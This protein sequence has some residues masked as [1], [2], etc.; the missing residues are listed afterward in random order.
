VGWF[1]LAGLALAVLVV[2]AVLFVS[3]RR[4]PRP[5]PP[6]PE[7]AA[8][9]S[10]PEGALPQPHEQ[11]AAALWR[12]AEELARSGDFLAAVRTLYLAVLSLLHRQ[13]LL[14]YEPTRTNG[15][16]VRQVRLADGAPPDLHVP[17]E[18]LTTR[19][20]VQWYGERACAAGDYAACRALAEEIRARVP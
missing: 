18:Q 9:G 5:A 4:G 11:S 14:S 15:E 1:L 20:E 8:P 3:A 16:Y 10:G 19:F 6:R 7:E 12:R 13:G 2:A 17:F